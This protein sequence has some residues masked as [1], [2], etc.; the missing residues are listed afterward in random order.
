MRNILVLTAVLLSTGAGSAADIIVPDYTDPTDLSW[1]GAYV[2]VSL[3]HANASYA[4]TDATGPQYQDYIDAFNGDFE[5][6]GWVLGGQ[7][8][9]NYQLDN[10]FVVG[11]QGL[12]LLPDLEGGYAGKARLRPSPTST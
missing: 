11:I 6:E 5:L 8:G 4:V 1:T 12:V 10:N 9:Y 7:V 3:G 2:G